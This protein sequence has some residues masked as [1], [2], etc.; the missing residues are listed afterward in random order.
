MDD[1]ELLYAL[2]G[3]IEDPFPTPKPSYTPP[4]PKPS[5]TCEID[6]KTTI[7]FVG[8]R[9]YGGYKP[10]VR[11]VPVFILPEAPKEVRYDLGME[12]IHQRAKDKRD[13]RVK[14]RIKQNA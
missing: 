11:V 10:P 9:C 6:R 13:A 2:L 12:R 5:Y 1:E 3:D 4:T 7:T 8:R 14:K